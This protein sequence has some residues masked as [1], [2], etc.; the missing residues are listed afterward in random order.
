M[1]LSLYEVLALLAR[2]CA[3]AGSQAAWARHHKLSDA[4]VSD[5]L[6]ERREPGAAILAALGVERVVAYRAVASP[7]LP[8][9]GGGA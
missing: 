7:A 2:E 8:R 3:E 9:D 6:R 1:K 5:V 4:Y